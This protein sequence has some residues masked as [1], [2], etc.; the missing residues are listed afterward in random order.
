M[1][2]WKGQFC[3]S[4]L[5]M[6][7]L[8]SVDILNRIRQGAEAIR[9]LATSQ[10]VKL[11]P[12]RPSNDLF[13]L[14]G[15]SETFELCRIL[16]LLGLSKWLSVSNRFSKSGLLSPG[17]ILYCVTNGLRFPQKRFR[18]R[19]LK[20]GISPVFGCLFRRATAVVNDTSCYGR[21]MQAYLRQHTIRYEKLFN[22]RAQ[23]PT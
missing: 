11:L 8:P 20:L 7:D 10:L 14:K 21:A 12:D 15:T 16:N 9:P 19:F 1:N 3:K 2:H 23:K 22:V 17:T 5:C 6:S 18:L 4:Y 13:R